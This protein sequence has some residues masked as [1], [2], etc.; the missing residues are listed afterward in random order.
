MATQQGVP[1]VPRDSSLASRLAPHWKGHLLRFERV[2]L[3][4]YAAGSGWR[5]LLI[6][7]LVEGVLGP[8]LGVLRMLGLEVPAAWIRV[9]LLLAIVLVLVVAFAKVRPSRLGFR[10]WRTWT[11]TEKS[12]FVQVLVLANVIFATIFAKH[13]AALAANPALWGTAGVV[14]VTT[15]LWGL[16]QELIYRGILQT[17]LTRRWGAAAG[18]LVANTLYTFGPLHF[19]HFAER[20]P[21][22]AA[23]MFAGIFAIGLFF[24]VLFRKTSNLWMVGIFH[25]IGDWYIVGVGSVLR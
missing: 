24:A 17:E 16:Y 15:L 2:P 13:V 8:R 7:L 11:P 1:T 23:I 5:L 22:G 21:A 6:V 3:E 4:P 19:Y 14:L 25:G 18:I 10:P 12:Y 9:P 20:T